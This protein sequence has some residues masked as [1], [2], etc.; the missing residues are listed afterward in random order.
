MGRFG[1]RGYCN[2]DWT[3]GY[4]LMISIQN[5]CSVSISLTSELRP[6]Y[7]GQV[8]L[9]CAASLHILPRACSTAVDLTTVH[10]SSSVENA[11]E[12]NTWN[13]AFSRRQL[14]NNP[15]LYVPRSQSW[16]G[17][18]TRN[19]G[20]A[21]WKSWI[22]ER[23]TS[24][25]HNWTDRDAILQLSGHLWP[26][27]MSPTLFH[28]TLAP[29]PYLGHLAFTAPSCQG[30]PGPDASILNAKSH[31]V[32]CPVV[33]PT[34][35]TDEPIVTGSSV[36]GIK[37]KDGV[38][39]AADMLAS[40]GGTKRYKSVQRMRAVGEHTLV[41]ASGEMSDFFYITMLLD[42]LMT[43]DYCC[44]DGSTLTP[45]DIHSYLTRVLYNRRNKFDPLWNNLVV[46][47][48][49][50]GQSF[51]GSVN[52]IGVHYEDSHLATGMGSHLCRP[53]FRNEHRE[54]MTEEEAR[55]LM[56][57]CMR[58]LYCRDR[59]SINKFQIATVTAAGVNISEPM[60]L[61]ADWDLQAF[62]NPSKR[63]EGT[64]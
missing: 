11:E 49:R 10:F 47:G 36:L 2:D 51:L 21:R 58:L 16:S 23:N 60:A 59:A 33:A 4:M 34:F 29:K 55:N 17:W 5:E 56:I 28:D 42:E 24:S 44:D 43:T 63:M 8:A 25:S 13:P 50:D 15:I 37:Y 27:V 30:N 12:Q 18:Q 6:S 48:F 46:A 22:Y 1:L 64:W 53:V 20:E 39:I 61:S 26:R 54:D 32:E 62:E 9:D 7:T 38:M 40:Y 45:K 14:N 52:M 35:H 41:G 31:L 3:I 19:P 57:K